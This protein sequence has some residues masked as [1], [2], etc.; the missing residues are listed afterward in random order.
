MLWL[1][2]MSEQHHAARPEPECEPALFIEF[3]NRLRLSPGSDA[4]SARADV[5][6]LRTWLAEHDLL[7]GRA[8]AATL[9][10]E[11]PAF[12]ELRTAITAIAGRLGHGK[13][14][15]RG[16]VD[17]INRALRDGLHYHALRAS[18]GGDFRMEQVGDEVQQARATIAGS[19]A[20]YLADHDPDRLRV[21]ADDTC[22]W[23]FVDESPAGRRRWCDMRT[24]GNRAKVARH[25][26]RARTG[27]RRQGDAG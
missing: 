11:L 8:N 23:L 22:R 9:Q 10:R 14:L 17:T 24:C 16:Q 7:H 27:I 4:D 2:E 1:H 26:A 20:H 3:A 19:L 5:A 13:A 21:C 6:T 15:T 12:R 25:R 18:N